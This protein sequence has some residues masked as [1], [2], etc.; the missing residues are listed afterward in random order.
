MSFQEV[1]DTTEEKMSKAVEVFS[2]EL[3]GIRT[4]RAT[5]GLVDNIRADY[6]GS[7]SPLKQIAA[8]SVPE[9]RVIVIKPFDPSCIKS[10][11]KA[12]L[13]SDLGMTPSSDGK[14][15]RLQVPPLSE[16]RRKQIVKQAK[17]LSEKAKNTLRSNRREGNDD[18]DKMKKNSDISEDECKKLKDKIQELIKKYEN[19]ISDLFQKKEKEI[20]E[21]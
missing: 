6:H 17:E 2:N 14:I 13:S 9:A 3:K 18:A 10:I 4:G 7:P 5:P 15:I 11:E 21:N 8:I 19:N 16:E 20:L 12:L 1:L